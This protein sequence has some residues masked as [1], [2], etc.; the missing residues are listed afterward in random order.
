MVVA[1]ATMQGVTLFSK[2]RRR[3]S[4]V[5]E[6]ALTYDGIEIRRPGESPRHLSWDRVSE[7]EI[8]QRRGGVLLTLRGGGSVT[9]L[10][11]PRWNVEELDVVLREVTSHAPPIELADGGIR[12]G[13]PTTPTVKPKAQA[14]VEVAPKPSFTATPPSRPKPPTQAPAAR[15]APTALAVPPTPTTT[16]T[17]ARSFEDVVS[18][19]LAPPVGPAAEPESS[20]VGGLVWP[21]E[22][23]LKEIPSLSWPSSMANA[24]GTAPSP[25]EFVLPDEPVST[26]VVRADAP[27]PQKMVWHDPAPTPAPIVDPLP[28][29]PVVDVLALVDDVLATPEIVPAP[30]PEPVKSPVETKPVMPQPAAPQPEAPKPWAAKPATKS[31]AT[32][33]P[34]P[35]TGEP[36][37]TALFI[38]P[39]EGAAETVAPRRADRREER[40]AKRKLER[41]QA[42]RPKAQAPKA[43]SLQTA[44]PAKAEPAKAEPAKAERPKPERQRAACP[45]AER[46]KAARQF[47]WRM[48]TTVVLLGVLALAV[49]LVLA[50][51]AGM[52]HLPFFGNPA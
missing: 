25:N 12:S 35:A 4:D 3:Q 19:Q 45:K 30:V 31:V 21:G 24:S 52:I 26:E 39:R 46:A 50:Q 20:E 15:T 44:A 41:R 22:A 27:P 7:W 11:I 40:Q 28:V 17:P 34:K 14:T 37:D 10:I 16:S 29:E 23:P 38:A 47:S 43:E 6:L 1:E 18:E 5:F 49:A 32:P 9:P 2:A 36:Q 51:S 13:V 33:T 48:V 8:E 42:E